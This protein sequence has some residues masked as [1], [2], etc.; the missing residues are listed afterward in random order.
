MKPKR[1]PVKE[2]QQD[3]FR[4]ELSK[5]IDPSHGRVKIANSVDWDRMDALFGETYCPDNGRP[6]VGTRLMVPFHYLE[7]TFNLSNDN[8]FAGWVE[9]PYCQ[10]FSGMKFFEHKAPILPS[11]MS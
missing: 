10:H 1:S 11:G 5:I 2:Q 9:N 4:V 7:Y 6:G 8:T 3:L